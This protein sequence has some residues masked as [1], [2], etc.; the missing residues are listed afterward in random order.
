[1]VGRVD[2]G[3]AMKGFAVCPVLLVVAVAACYERGRTQIDAA[4]PIDVAGISPCPA[5]LPMANAP[6]DPANTA[7]CQ[8]ETPGRLRCPTSATC[9]GRLA[10]W[11][12]TQPS[13]TCGTAPSPCPAMFTRIVGD[14]C[15]VGNLP[16]SCDYDEGRCACNPCTRT[17]NGQPIM[18][19]EWWCRSW[20]SAGATCSDVQPLLGSTC[21][22]EGQNCQ[23]GSSSSCVALGY[24]VACTNFVW[25]V[26]PSQPPDMCPRQCLN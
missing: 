22:F 14:P 2:R 15:P 1:M 17:V 20:D 4:P 5:F 25:R 11:S 23:Y 6:C 3:T 8:Y 18:D 21:V 16:S 26:D 13:P 10:V 9:D 7:L 24:D 19:T 12:I